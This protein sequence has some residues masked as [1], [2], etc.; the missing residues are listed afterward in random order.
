M[1]NLI[2]CH[3]PLFISKSSSPSHT[4]FHHSP[5]LFFHSSSSSSSSSP[6]PSWRHHHEE[7][8]RTVKVSVWWDFENC[9]VP[10]GVNVFRVGQRI[11]SALRANGMKGPVTITAFGDVSQ[12][13]RSNQEALSST[14]ICIAHVPRCGKNSADRSLLLD[15]VSWVSQNPPPAHLFLISGDRDFANLLHRLRMNNYNILLA[16][17]DCTSG[18]LCSAASIMWHWN[19]LVRGDSLLG[20]HFNHPPDGVYGSWYGHYNGPLDDPFS[21]SEQ[22]ALL[23][24]ENSPE[25]GMDVKPRPIPKA[26][27]D[28]I[29]QI[30]NSYPDGVSLSELRIELGKTNITVDKDFFGYKKFSRFL[31]S[32]PNVLKLRRHPSGDQPL[33]YGIHPITAESIPS[34]SKPST[35]LD[36]A[37]GNMDHCPFG[38]GLPRP[39][40]SDLKPSTDEFVDASSKTSTDEAMKCDL[41][42]KLKGAL[43][44]S[45]HQQATDVCSSAHGE[46]EEKTAS[47]SNPLQQQDST[48]EEGFFRRIWKSWFGHRTGKEESN[49]GTCKCS[50]NS[51]GQDADP[52][53]RSCIG[54]GK[55][56]NK[57]ETNQSSDHDLLGSNL[58]SLNERKS[59]P[60][61]RTLDERKSALKERTI[62]HSE[63]NDGKS[64]SNSKKSAPEERTIGHS[65]KNDGKS[66]SNSNLLKPFVEWLKFWKAREKHPEHDSVFADES[67]KTDDTG[68]LS[69]VVSQTGCQLENHELF[70]KPYFWNDMESFFRTTKGAALITRSITREQMA[71]K[72]DNKGPLIVKALGANHFPRLVDMLISEKKWVEESESQTFPFK[73]TLPAKESHSSTPH[74]HQTNGL[75]SMFSITKSQSNVRQQS[76]KQGK[77]REDSH[78]LNES[79]ING[80]V[81]N[82]QPQNVEELKVWLKKIRN[83]TGVIEA[84][85]FKRYF[86]REFNKNLD[87][88]FYGYS[89]FKCLYM[90]CSGDHGKS[91]KSNEKPSRHKSKLEADCKNLAAEILQ[92]YPEEFNIHSFK[93]LFYERYGY[94]LDHE[95]LGHSTLKSLLQKVTP[96]VRIRAATGTIPILGKVKTDVSEEKQLQREASICVLENKIRKESHSDDDAAALAGRDSFRDATINQDSLWEELG[97]VTEAGHLGSGS[98]SGHDEVGPV[99]EMVVRANVG[100][101]SEGNQEMS[102][103]AVLEKPSISDEDLSDSEEENI[104]TGAKGAEK[105]RSLEDSSLLKI[106]NSW[107]SNKDGSG[108]DSMENIDGLVDCSRSRGSSKPSESSAVCAEKM[109]RAATLRAKLRTRKNY[110]FI[111]DSSRD[112]EEQLIDGILGT[113]RKSADSKVQS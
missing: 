58:G 40:S 43:P 111:S 84:E 16:S 101:D 92:E 78:F 30:L 54:S 42:A 51:S 104:A 5:F 100:Y 11:I 22:P 88:G 2:Q 17:T 45:S 99:P 60:E 32:M 95:K 27:V 3:F 6:T 20:K 23:Q 86:E 103:Q 48:G 39:K 106:L 98:E 61:E 79:P 44:P 26:L 62:G 72:L 59:A 82:K 68:K 28:R 31:L 89:S 29:R 8:S 102:Y 75:S 83:W 69:E 56:Q 35:G 64:N 1:R 18:V 66:N 71:K 96:G 63:K 94:E 91:V 15:L 74:A 67:T 25:T 77:K 41:T 38:D 4:L 93:A 65:E 33:V 109:H 19:V 90:E 70:S 52:N 107:Y 55:R 110:S 46:I 97:P 36:I 53:S 12:L 105:D 81:N 80:N 49:S 10:A 87:C 73:L 76:D 21:D 112:D 14:G 47:D 108:K 7:Q 113:L 85:D 37:D 50:A 13:S 24:P 9:S 57:E 34:N